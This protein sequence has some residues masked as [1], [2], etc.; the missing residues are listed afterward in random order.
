MNLSVGVKG[1]VNSIRQ[2]RVTSEL[3]NLNISL[4][5][6]DEL[7]KNM[8]HSIVTQLSYQTGYADAKKN[9][10]KSK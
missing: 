9:K 4:Q 5:E 7:S 10:K 1:S 2:M 6:R 3:Q 8:M